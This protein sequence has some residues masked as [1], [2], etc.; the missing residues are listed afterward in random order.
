MNLFFHKQLAWNYYWIHNIHRF[1]HY[2]PGRIRY[3]IR[4]NTW[5]GFSR[6][7]KIRSS[8][9]EISPR[10]SQIELEKGAWALTC[11][12]GPRRFVYYV[13]DDVRGEYAV[14]AHPPVAR[15]SQKA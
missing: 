13:I 2:T 11:G 6:R 14:R 7:L 3:K 15:S 1:L 12:T 5:P 10:G 4:Q 9:S 8:S